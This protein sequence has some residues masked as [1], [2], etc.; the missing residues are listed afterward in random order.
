MPEV[1]EAAAFAVLGAVA[2]VASVAAIVSRQ[3]RRVAFW[4]AVAMLAASGGMSMLSG[5]YAAVTV[6]LLLAVATPSALLLLALPLP[7]AAAPR[8]SRL[9]FSAVAASALGAAGVVALSSADPGRVSSPAP[10]GAA[11]F[12][13]A[14][15]VGWPL[16]VPALGVIALAV[17]VAAPLRTRERQ[18]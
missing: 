13:H 2:L 10:L 5:G 3:P 14:L 9:L 12:G 1:V 15:F 16:A 6:F 8:R 11:G 17:M 4:V 18:K 7:P